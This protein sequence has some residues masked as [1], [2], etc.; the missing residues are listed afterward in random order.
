[1]PSL[2]PRKTRFFGIIFYNV[3][4][5]AFSSFRY[6]LFYLYTLTMSSIPLPFLYVW[7]EDFTEN[8]QPKTWP[9]LESLLQIKRLRPQDLENRDFRRQHR[10]TLGFENPRYGAPIYE[11]DIV[12]L[13]NGMYAYVLYKGPDNFVLVDTNQQ[14]HSFADLYSNTSMTSRYV[15]NDLFDECFPF[16]T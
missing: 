13:Q 15:N 5:R 6:S 8:R 2:T 12:T 3:F 11:L 4:W 1:V 7:R 14:E 16:A 9:E 10:L